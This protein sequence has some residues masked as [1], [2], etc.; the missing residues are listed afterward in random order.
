MF[1]PDGRSISLPVREA[2][3][4]DAIQIL[5]VTTGASRLAAT[6]P[7]HVSFRASWVDNGT[8]LIVNRSDLVT[9]IAMFDRFWTKDRTQ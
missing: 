1:S 3:D 2:R 8:A 5:D 4:H 6:L 9:H 7:F